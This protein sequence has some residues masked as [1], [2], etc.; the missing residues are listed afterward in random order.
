MAQELKNLTKKAA[1]AAEY[2]VDHPYASIKEIADA[3]AMHPATLYKYR[4]SEIY[5]G[6]RDELLRKK[7]REAQKIAMD[8]MIKLAQDEDREAC[9]FIL[10]TQGI[11]TEIRTKVEANV[12]TNIKISVK[13]SEDD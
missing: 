11:S 4:Q 6:Y 7:W 3:C 9:K 13:D 10:S 12:D 1:C 8:T 5:Q 2:E